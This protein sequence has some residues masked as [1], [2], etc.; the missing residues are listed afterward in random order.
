MERIEHKSFDQERA[1][2][3][4]RDTQVVNCRFEGPADGESAFKECADVEAAGGSSTCATPSG[5]M[6]GS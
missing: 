5:T 2:Y 3:G 1:L 4:L 6:R